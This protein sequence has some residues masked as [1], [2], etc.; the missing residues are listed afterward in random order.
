MNRQAA[1][2]W[3]HAV[4]RLAAQEDFLAA[5]IT[6]AAIFMFLATGLQVVP[7]ALSQIFHANGGSDR[8]ASSALLLNIAVILFAW[9]RQKNL[10]AEAARRALAEARAEL[11][12]SRDQLTNLLVRSSLAESGNQLVEEVRGRGEQVGVLVLNLDRFKN[13]NDVYGHVAGDTLLRAVANAIILTVPPGALCARLGADE[14]AVLIPLAENST[15]SIMEIAD[16][17]VAKAT[18]PIEVGASQIHT[19]AS[20]GISMTRADCGEVDGLLRRANI[21]MHAA[22]GAGGDRAVWFD[23]SMESVLKARND[24]E[25]GLRRGIPLGEFI[26]YYQPQ[27]D[28]ATGVLCGFEVLARW[29]HPAGGVVGPELFIPVSEE[30]GLIG[31]LFDSIFHQALSDARSW[32]GDFVLAVNVSPGQLKDPWLA[33]RILKILTRTNFPPERVEIEITES[34]LFENLAV[35]QSV[36]A[37]LKNQGLRLALDDFGTGYSSLS[38]LRALPFDRIK[39]DRSFVQSM[40]RDA[41][42]LAIVTAVTSMSRS[43]GVPVTA[44]GVEDLATEKAVRALGCDKAQGWLYGKALSR[45]DT[46]RY[47][48]LDRPVVDDRREDPGAA[49][50]SAA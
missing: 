17:L 13:V 11:L 32:G 10:R 8:V 3:W 16:N 45:E 29:Q 15:A 1:L 23:N 34:S 9:R 26:P 40:S 50:R 7:A 2:R 46:R 49:A 24:V 38:N 37:S 19:G 35:A 22:K 6:I 39:I 31:E 4:A 47:L 30:T 42:S 36:V 21:A 27:I 5:G 41:S 28:L 43:L 25:A 44:E 33:H 12:A 14:F 48:D 18:A 20:V